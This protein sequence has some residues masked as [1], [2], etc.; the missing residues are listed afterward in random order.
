[1]VVMASA[2]LFANGVDHCLAIVE[3]Y[4]GFLRREL[5]RAVAYCFSARERRRSSREVDTMRIR[6]NTRRLAV[7]QPGQ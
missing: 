1:M 3:E 2:R 5:G 4:L 7:G 6:C